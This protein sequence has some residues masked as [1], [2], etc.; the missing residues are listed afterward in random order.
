M[1]MNAQKN[2]NSI[3]TTAEESVFDFPLMTRMIQKQTISISLINPP[4]G[5]GGVKPYPKLA[6][7][8]CD[9]GKFIIKIKSL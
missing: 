8:K 7:Q 6:S 5:N 3:E 9:A 4:S 1:E 2:I